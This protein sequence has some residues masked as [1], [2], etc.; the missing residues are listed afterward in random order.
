MGNIDQSSLPLDS[1][2]LVRMPRIRAQAMVVRVI[3][4]KLTDRPPMP[5]I[6]IAETTNRFLLAPRLTCWIIFRPE[7]AIKPYSATQTPPMTQ[8]GMDARKVTK[9]PKKEMTMHIIAAVVMVTT[10]AFRVMATQ[11]TDSP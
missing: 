3:S 10:E 9:G 4:P 2:T 8:L 1:I 6:R 11:P 7:T 5:G